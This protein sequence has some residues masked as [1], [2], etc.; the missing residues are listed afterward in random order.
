MSGELRG[1]VLVLEAETPTLLL[2]ASVISV[3][4]TS[5]DDGGEAVAAERDGGASDACDK[6]RVSPRERLSDDAKLSLESVRCE[7]ME[8]ADERERV[9]RDGAEA[10]DVDRGGGRSENV[11]V[12]PKLELKVQTVT[13]AT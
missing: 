9:E 3:S 6:T 12:R 10:F 4:L 13:D 11:R 5:S 8:R 7:A 2:S 1:V